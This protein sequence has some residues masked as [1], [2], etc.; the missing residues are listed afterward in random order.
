MDLGSS[1]DSRHKKAD[2]R[3]DIEHQLA[4]QTEKKK[5]KEA[6]VSLGINLS[7]LR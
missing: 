7:K 6:S 1:W 5:K 4:M 3:R 2:L